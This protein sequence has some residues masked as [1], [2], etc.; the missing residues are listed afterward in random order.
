V[1]ASAHGARRS[2]VFVTDII[3]PYTIA[4]MTELAGL[5]DL[6]VLFAT[7]RSGRGQ[8][9]AFSDLPF[10][11]V[12]VG[13]LARR[14]GQADLSDYYLSPRILLEL[15]RSSPDAIITGGWSFPS[16]YAALYARTRKRAL[17]IHSDGS[18]HTEEALS[19]VQRVS[20]R[21]LVPVADGFAPNTLSAAERFRELGARPEQL[22]HAPHS[23]NL[24]PFWAAEPRHDDSRSEIR[25]LGTGRLLRRKGFDRLLAAFAAAQAEDPRLELRL[26]GTGPADER[27]RAETR[28]LGL[29]SVEFVGFVDQPQLARIYA[30]SDIFASPSLQEE[31]GF[32][33]LEAMAAGL[34]CI[35]SSS[36]GATRDLIRDGE[37]GIAVD[38]YDQRAW[39]RALVSLA[40]DPDARRRLG[41][42]AR[43]NSLERTPL[44]TARGYLAGVED[45][46][47]QREQRIR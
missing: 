9:W 18:S 7:A 3:T 43:Q 33:L 10:R 20:R 13:G 31:F 37:N 30:E 12:V 40:A 47:S 27:L 25:V 35:A 41:A 21:L 36:A 1:T 39:T 46:L 32:V 44:A 4:V 42:A 8:D 38:P 45:I 14:R 22:H 17:I 15:A 19:R 28:S 34:P 6:T 26:V 29:K 24:A 16:Y 2:L 11:H 23:T 5:A